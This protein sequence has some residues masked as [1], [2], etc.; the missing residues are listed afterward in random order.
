MTLDELKDLK[1]KLDRAVK[2]MVSFTETLNKEG[3][4][5]E[6]VIPEFMNRVLCTETKTEMDL[7]ATSLMLP[8]VAATKT[9]EVVL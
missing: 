3:F 4:T 5:V 2:Q 1:S 7:S 9:Q 8:F 6:I